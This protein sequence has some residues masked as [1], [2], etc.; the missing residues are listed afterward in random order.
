M[1]EDLIFKSA[2]KK[3]TPPK[4]WESPSIKEQLTKAAVEY[5]LD[6]AQTWGDRINSTRDLAQAGVTL[7]ALP[8]GPPLATVAAAEAAPAAEAVIPWDMRDAKAAEK[9]AEMARKNTEWL[10]RRSA[11]SQKAAENYLGRRAT[12]TAAEAAAQ[13]SRLSQLFGRA[14]AAAPEFRMKGGSRWFKA[15]LGST[16]AGLAAVPAVTQAMASSALDDAQDDSIRTLQNMGYD[17]RRPRLGFSELPGWFTGMSETGPIDMV[18]AAVSPIRSEAANARALKEAG[19]PNYVVPA[20]D[21]N[22][23]VVLTP[24]GVEVGTEDQE[25]EMA[26]HRA[27]KTYERLMR[28]LPAKS[29][30]HQAR[31]GE[32]GL[33]K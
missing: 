2:A 27:Y 25:T 6:E 33:I 32:L 23:L 10:A 24:D 3:W 7:M 18:R 11:M 8:E 21:P 30:R 31:A 1:S 13:P 16:L 20:S 9:A 22:K 4:N 19:D 12:T 28:D 29:G 17:V 26:R 15:G 14:R 5:A